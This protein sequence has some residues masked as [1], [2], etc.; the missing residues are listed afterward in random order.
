MK[1]S[2]KFVN[3]SVSREHKLALADA[4][5]VLTAYACGY[6]APQALKSQELCHAVG[7]SLKEVISLSA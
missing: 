2:C 4:M 6:G 5:R 7:R 3:Q 1:N